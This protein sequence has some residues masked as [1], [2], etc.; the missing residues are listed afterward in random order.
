MVMTTGVGV[1]TL[2]EC[3]FKTLQLS[4]GLN[5]QVLGGDMMR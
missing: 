5:L 3:V 1:A 4:P 2:Q